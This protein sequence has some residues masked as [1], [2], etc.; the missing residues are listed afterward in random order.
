M[1]HKETDAMTTFDKAFGLIVRRINDE[2]FD[3]PS[4]PGSR[5]VTI[6][7]ARFSRL[8]C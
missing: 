3:V 8:K 2:P 4:V 5:A 7:C 1:L 6:R